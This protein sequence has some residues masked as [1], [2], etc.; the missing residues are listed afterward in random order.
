MTPSL[1]VH[2]A[3]GW[4]LSHIAQKMAQAAPDEYTLTVPGA[5]MSSAPVPLDPEVVQRVFYVDIQNC[6]NPIW[7][8]VFPHATH[9]GMFTHL[10]RDSNESFRPG[11][12]ELH[13]VVH[14]AHRY[15]DRFEQAG[16][17]PVERM[18]V[19]R[20]GEVHQFPMKRTKI[21]ICQ[22]GEH[23][24][25]GRDF[26]PATIQS[27]SPEVRG[28][29]ELHFKGQG[30]KEQFTKLTYRGAMFTGTGQWVPGSDDKAAVEN[31]FSGDYHGVPAYAYDSEA[32]VS[33]PGFYERLDYLLIPSLWE[34]GPMS[35]LEALACGIPVIAPDVG[36]CPE[37]E[38]AVA[39][40]YEAGNTDDLGF[41]LEQIAGRRITRRNAVAGM[42][43][44]RYA[45]GVSTFF[46]TIE[47]LCR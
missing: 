35:L 18:T 20:P 19:L 1:I 4:I 6:W 44:A 25:K 10:D 42:S 27:L 29:M 39:H 11:W 3:S 32:T 8:S 33:Y 21:G 12:D 47:E 23:P 38:G 5:W 30:W 24:G 15:M 36:W 40:H 34:G 16:W 46:S 37:F 28:C 17:Y 26:L 41:A 7:K 13:G 43:Y 31:W 14:M 22:R 45:Q 2:P 9:V